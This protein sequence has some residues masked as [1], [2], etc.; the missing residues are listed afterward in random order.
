MNTATL[1]R[2][3]DWAWEI[4]K[5]GT[6][7]VPGI[8]FA[9]EE[10]VG[11]M[12]E[13]VR[14]QM[15]NV[16]S[17]P[18]IVQAAYAMPDAHWGYG[19]PIGGVAAFDPQE[20]GVVSAG[21][22][23][24]DIS[25]GVRTLLTA[26]S[27]EDI[28]P[29][30][31]QLADGLFQHVPAGVGSTSR[32]R[33]DER[34]LTAMLNGGARWAVGAGYGQPADL[35]RIEQGGRYDGADPAQVSGEARHRQVDEMGTLG[36][37]NHYLEL[38]AVTD[39]YD[40]ATADAFGLAVGAVVVSIHCGS[41]GLGH[42]VA[43]EFA[44][45]M[46]IEGPGYGIRLADR[47]LASVPIDSPVGRDYFGAMLAAANCAL[48][49]R[50]ILA[51]FVRE[52]FERVTGDGNLSLLY[53]V[54]HNVCSL[55]THEIAGRRRDVYVHRKGATRSLGPGAADVPADLKAI[56]Q[57]VLIG[58]SMGTCS[59]ILAGTAASETRAFSSACHG[60][61]RCQSRSQS[62]RQ[63]RGED[64][65]ER[66]RRRH[67]TIKSRSLRGVAEEAP[68]AYKDVNAV[69][70]VTHAAGLAR[71]VARLAPLICVKG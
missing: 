58:G 18:G 39:V 16:A 3:D 65:V 35:G 56:G 48:A 63:N 32:L 49:N 14:E 42:Q 33:L 68:T 45:R 1:N 2:L 6:M 9:S 54:S 28:E 13:K 67:I 29:L 50:Q 47:E 57:P 24:F 34:E 30:R 61:G 11:G 4:P 71:K 40:P 60:A 46:V 27:V 15:S 36:S 38:Q 66:L 19:F 70:E 55:E 7:R 37:G 20:G 10:L 25:C 12:D 26:L 17:L 8:I 69:V 23:G 51:H 62:M 53:D 31:A 52:V 22:V 5:S 43:T 41:R 59:Y 44:R 21:G 64:V